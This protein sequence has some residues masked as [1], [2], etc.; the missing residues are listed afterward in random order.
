MTSLGMMGPA[1]KQSVPD[2][3]KH[4]RHEQPTMRSLAIEALSKIEQDAD[5]VVPLLIDALKDEDWSVRKTA[6]SSLG[7]IGS[8][9]RAAV[10]ILFELLASETDRDAA[11]SALREIDDVG[12]EAVAVLIKE[13]D[14]GDLRLRYYAAYYIG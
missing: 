14:S 8:P 10:P 9:A 11:R 13:L 2:L 6:A 7:R 12:P 1:A 4:L 5:K 3:E